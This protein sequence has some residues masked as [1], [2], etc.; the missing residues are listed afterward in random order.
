MTQIIQTKETGAQPI[1]H[2]NDERRL[3]S[4]LMGMSTLMR[5]LGRALLCLDRDLRVVHASDSLDDLAGA[6]AAARALGLAASDLP[7][8]ELFGADGV[9]GS[10]A[11][12]WLAAARCSWTRS[13]TCRCPCR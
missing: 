8:E 2:V 9:T 5:S 12:R 10:A 7:G 13:A 11:S 3:Q 1:G 6:G 4:L